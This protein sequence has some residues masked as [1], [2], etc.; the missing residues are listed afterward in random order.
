M[1]ILFF[2]YS[3]ISYRTVELLVERRSQ[4]DEVVGVVTHRD[5]PAENRWYRTPAEAALA[6]GLPL[7]YDEELGPEGIVEL[8]RQLAPDLVLSVFYR[9]LLPDAV[10]DT[11]RL[12]ALNLHPSLLPA[13]RGRAPLNWVLVNG[14][15]ETGVTLHHMVKR[16]DAGDVVA[17][18]AI[19]I[20]PRDTALSL[21]HKIETAG[22]ELLRETLPLVASGTAPRLRQDESRASKVGRRR[23]EDGRIDW[24]WPAARVDN[25]VRAVAPPWPGAFFDLPLAAGAPAGH[26]VFV[27]AGEPAEPLPEGA[28]RPVP[29]TVRQASGH[30]YIAAA[31]RWYRVDEA[32]GLDAQA[33]SART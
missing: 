17:Q 29:G 18:R 22:V 23:P 33:D 10:L 16:A 13:Y 26:R 4:G 2:G 12:A 15:T 27:H 28:E 11:A 6:H 31:D 20:A 24:S 5:D 14:E 9:H 8:A 1:R 19:P 21:Y 32:V 30:T 3:Q 7:F 25:L